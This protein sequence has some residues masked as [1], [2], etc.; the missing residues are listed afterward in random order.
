MSSKH[1]AETEDA[2]PSNKFFQKSWN[3]LL[4]EENRSGSPKDPL[5]RQLVAESS[6]RTVAAHGS[7]CAH[8]TTPAT[9]RAAVGHQGTP[10]PGHWAPPWGWDNNEL[11][12]GPSLVGPITGQSRTR[13]GCSELETRLCCGIVE[14]GLG[15]DTQGCWHPKGHHNLHITISKNCT[16]RAHCSFCFKFSKFHSY[17]IKFYLLLVNPVT[18]RYRSSH[19]FVFLV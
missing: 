6:K 8:P 17:L 14:A 1:S 12:C 7:A 10:S 5:E 9:S 3:P 19:L 16:Q 4:L 18:S 11:G 13:K 15:R 2:E